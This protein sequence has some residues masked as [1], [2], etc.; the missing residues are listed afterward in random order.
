MGDGVNPPT[1]GYGGLFANPNPPEKRPLYAIGEPQA[2][3]I[4]VGTVLRVKADHPAMVPMKAY[5]DDAGLDMHVSE[6]VVIRPGEFKDV[7]SGIS[8]QLPEG[9]WG[10]IQGRSSTLRKRSL[11]VNPGV[12]D[13]GYRGPLFSGCWNLGK[14]TVILE[15][16]ER[17][18]QLI[19]IANVTEMVRVVEVDE[20]ADHPR[21]SNGFGS[22]GT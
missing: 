17:V 15:E 9:T 6:R 16:G 21:G 1:I 12:I 11:L 8:V 20:L 7:P 4:L 14:E 22:S 10:M 5:E 19:L 18:A 2:E 3:H 13:V